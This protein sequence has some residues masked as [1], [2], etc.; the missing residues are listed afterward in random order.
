M[1]YSVVQEGNS[2]GTTGGSLSQTTGSGNCLIVYVVSGS[3]TP[4]TITMTGPGTTMKCLYYSAGHNSD[5]TGIF[6][7]LNTPNTITGVTYSG[8]NNASYREV[9]GIP[10]NPIIYWNFGGNATAGTT[11]SL[12]A[13]GG[14]ASGDFITFDI[15]Y[16]VSNAGT[17]YNDGLT[18]DKIIYNYGQTSYE[19]AGNSASAATMTS[20]TWDGCMADFKPTNQTGPWSAVGTIVSQ[21]VNTGQTSFTISPVNL[22]DLLVVYA[23]VSSSTNYVTG[24]SGAAEDGWIQVVANFTDGNATPHTQNAWIAKATSTGSTTLTISYASSIGTTYSELVFQEFSVPNAINASYT[25]DVQGNHTNGAA[26]YSIGPTLTPSYSTGELLIGYARV[27]GAGTCEYPTA[28]CVVQTDSNSNPFIYALNICSSIFFEFWD[29]NSVVSYD[30]G[31]LISVS[32]P[33]S[34]PM[35]RYYPPYSKYRPSLYQPIV[36]GNMLDP[37]GAVFGPPIAP[38]TTARAPMT[39]YYPQYS[40]YRP[41]LYQPIVNQSIRD[42]SGAINGPTIA[43]PTTDGGRLD[44]RFSQYWYRQPSLYEPITSGNMQDPSG[45]LAGPTIA[46][47]TTSGGRLIQRPPQ[48]FYRQPSLYEPIVNGNM[49]DASGAST[50]IIYQYGTLTVSSV[51]MSIG[52]VSYQLPAQETFGVVSAIVNPDANQLSTSTIASAI[53]AITPDAIQP[54]IVTIASAMSGWT[55]NAV[56]TAV[57]TI[58]SASSMTP[59]AVLQAIATFAGVTTTPTLNAIQQVSATIASATGLTQNAVQQAIV[60]IAGAVS[61]ITPAPIQQAIATI[62]STTS[63][64]F[65]NVANAIGTFTSA[66]TTSISAVA[67]QI[68]GAT[69][70]SEVDPIWNNVQQVIADFEVDA[71]SIWNNIQRIV[72][73]LDLES[74]FNPPY[75]IQQVIGTLSAVTSI[76][77]NGLSLSWSTVTMALTSSANWLSNQFST[78]TMSDVV[79]TIVPNGVQQAIATLESEIDPV[80]NNILQAVAT[81]TGSTSTSPNAVQQAIMTIASASSIVANAVQQ[82]IST[83]AASISSITSNA[84]QTSISSMNSTVSTWVSNA[85]QQVIAD[86]EGDTGSIVSNAIQQVTAT[87]A[88]NTSLTGT[89]FVQVVT[90]IL[91]AVTSALFSSGNWVYGLVTMAVSSAM[92]SNAVQQAIATFESEI[93]PI[94]VSLQNSFTSMAVQVSN[95]VSDANQTAITTLS[96]LTG[97]SPNAIQQVIAT[98]TGQVSIIGN[99]VQQ[100]IATLAGNASITPN[101]V[102]QVIA[103]LES[104]IDP[105]LN[106]VQQSITTIAANMPGWVSDAIQQSNTTLQSTSSMTQNAVLQAIATLNAATGMT[107]NAI[108]TVA[109]LV[110]L[111]AVS[112]WQSNAVQTAITNLTSTVNQLGDVVQIGTAEFDA[113]VSAIFSQLATVFGT[114]V[115]AAQSAMN[116]NAVQQAI[117]ALSSGTD[118][119]GSVV[120]PAVFALIIA[121][122]YTANVVQQA[123]A[124]L[125]ASSSMIASAIVHIFK[126]IAYVLGGFVTP[127]QIGG[128]AVQQQ[129]GGTATLATRGL[130]GIASTNTPGGSV[131][132]TAKPSYSGTATPTGLAGNITQ[133]IISGLATIPKIFGGNATSTKS[134]SGTGETEDDMAMWINLEAPQGNDTTWNLQVTNNGAPMNITGCVL[135]LIVKASN[136]TNDDAALQTYQIGSGLVITNAVAGRLTFTQAST[137]PQSAV[138]GTYWWRLDVTDLYGNLNTAMDGNLYILAV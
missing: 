28:P 74:T 46:P 110:L 105:A 43:P 72:A 137:D 50:A 59:N 131:S 71:Y 75:P 115:M 39:R 4:P 41:T 130:S 53:S 106:V 34:S 135:T 101:A 31:A 93:D 64:V 100:A 124:T 35:T 118:L 73:E 25:A 15:A 66:A 16:D 94:W 52:P 128:T 37:S 19:A 120:Q 5:Y 86:L 70:E 77:A 51:V 123:T 8:I 27:P 83:I 91:N 12:G 55:S 122:D 84:V 102:L 17:P 14:S 23:K 114:V 62:S 33:P 127:P 125:S 13:G 20:G 21:Y 95:W 49:L 82:S 26:N 58:A 117:S 10:T 87:I 47:P 54:A 42:A 44:Q 81:I 111:I 109:Q 32:V 116:S 9:S 129:L 98:I 45:A 88:G 65:Q 138:P 99:A 11:W 56:Q 36:H 90:A 133:K 132:Y 6:Y 68:V 85:I 134:L 107:Q 7:C 30:S 67:N 76:V 38:P 1:S 96:S 136:T 63:G 48:F 57:A 121:A 113:V 18:D 79:S 3:A 40:K 80:W 119:N 112:T 126:V 92:N 103:T 89:T 24:I 22:G 60:T 69:L 97:I 2:L 108:Q 104:E 61:G 78:T 29:T